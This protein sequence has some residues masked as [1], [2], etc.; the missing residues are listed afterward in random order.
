[1]PKL[2]CYLTIKKKNFKLQI[3]N[4]PETSPPEKEIPLHFKLKE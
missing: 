1:M 4:M 3:R 2:P